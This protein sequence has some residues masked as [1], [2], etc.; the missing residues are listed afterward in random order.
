MSWDGDNVFIN[1]YI[2]SLLFCDIDVIISVKAVQ[3]LELSKMKHNTPISC[4][5]LEEPQT[6]IHHHPITAA[7]I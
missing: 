6:A 5:S 3:C 1:L 7:L 2:F 4:L